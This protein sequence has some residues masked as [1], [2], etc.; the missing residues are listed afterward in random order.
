MT[1]SRLHYSLLLAVATTGIARCQTALSPEQIVRKAL[2][3]SPA[4]RAQVARFQARQQT[5]KS[6]G[7]GSNPELEL[8]PGVGFT[9][10]N[11]VLGQSFDLSGR[12]SAQ[13]KVAEAESKVASA[14][15]FQTRLQIAESVLS[16]YAEFLWSVEVEASAAQS[17]IAAEQ[18]LAGVEKRIGIGEAPAVQRTRAEVEL[19]RTKQA[20]T[21]A[22][23]KHASNLAAL[24]NALGLPLAENTSASGWLKI[25]ENASSALTQRPEA[26][27][28]RAN[29][30]SARAS[31]DEARSLG[32]PTIFAGVAADSWSLNRS[33]FRSENLGFQ[34]SLKMPIFDRGENRFA[35]RSA[36]L[37][38]KGRDA[39]LEG[40][41]RQIKLEVEQASIAR[42][43][44]SQVASS[45][46][47]GIVPKAEEMLSVMRQGYESG[48]VNFL[49]VLEAQQTLSRLRREAADATRALRLAEIRYLA[50]IAQLPGLETTQR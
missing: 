44:A 3:T 20:H 17:V 40:V 49:E 15:L 2:D 4:V 24:N 10:S 31:E 13:T 22:K 8:A 23:A 33:P 21:E 45:Y 47:S 34:V 50:A 37:L 36:E 18:I 46:A 12:R 7:A 6:L 30:E 11:F 27:R 26:L 29:I 16:V 5:A 32:R 41:E 25:A 48:L 1:Y 9:N 19:L 35:L 39:D 28:A 42:T 43:A 38:R 14:E